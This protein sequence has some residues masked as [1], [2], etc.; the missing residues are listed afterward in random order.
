M[1]WPKQTN[2]NVSYCSK[3]EGGLR[4]TDRVSLCSES[5]ANED[6]LYRLSEI[7]DR[8]LN[9]CPVQGTKLREN[10]HRNVIPPKLRGNKTASHLTDDAC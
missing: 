5:S 2:F 3:E 6:A 7:H 10:P 9:T 4:V 1:R 8:L